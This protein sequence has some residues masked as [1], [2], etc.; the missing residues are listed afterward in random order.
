MKAVQEIED[1]REIFR[2]FEE[3]TRCLIA[4]PRAELDKELAQYEREKKQRRFATGRA[5][6]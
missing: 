1:A 4:V 2:K 6:A 5:G 3:L